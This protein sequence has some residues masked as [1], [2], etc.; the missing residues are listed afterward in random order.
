MATKAT[1]FNC[2]L[3]VRF[4]IHRKNIFILYFNVFSGS[5]DDLSRD[6]SLPEEL[7]NEIKAKG[8]V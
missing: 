6:T 5:E 1:N 2:K 7:A 3:C 4:N 8:N